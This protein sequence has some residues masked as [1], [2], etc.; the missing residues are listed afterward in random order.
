[1]IVFVGSGFHQPQHFHHCVLHCFPSWLPKEEVWGLLLELHMLLCTAGGL[2]LWEHC[3]LRWVRA[4][5][6]L[7]VVCFPFTELLERAASVCFHVESSTCDKCGG[8][9]G[10]F[11]IVWKRLSLVW[12]V[13]MMSRINISLWEVCLVSRITHL[14]SSKLSFLSEYKR[15]LWGTKPGKQQKVQQGGAGSCNQAGSWDKCL[16]LYT[17]IPA[18]RNIFHCNNVLI[19]TC[20]P[21]SHEASSSA[22]LSFGSQAMWSN[23]TCTDREVEHEQSWGMSLPQ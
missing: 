13:C 5:L 17:I 15:G 21:A 3:Q 23:C 16:G 6:G 19:C 9:P 14:G 11:V 1:M 22:G 12:R 18:K 2:S 10:W 7:G 20:M 8:D 4:A